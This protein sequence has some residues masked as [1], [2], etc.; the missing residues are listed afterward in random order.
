[1]RRSAVT[2]NYRTRTQLL[3][4]EPLRQPLERPDRPSSRA[5]LRPL[6]MI[7]GEEASRRLRLLKP[8]REIRARYRGTV[9]RR[10][11]CPPTSRVDDRQDSPPGLM[12][13][14]GSRSAK[15][16]G[17]GQTLSALSSMVTME[18]R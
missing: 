14:I 6:L 11:E 10:F 2:T 8:R 16:P 7:Q 3:P 17:H 12:P 5:Q 18:T 9:P 1:M 4:F 15:F 13:T